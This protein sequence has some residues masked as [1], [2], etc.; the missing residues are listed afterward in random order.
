MPR[1]TTF[2]ADGT[3]TVQVTGAGAA[4]PAATPGAPAAAPRPP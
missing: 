1:H 2:G 4:L 3:A